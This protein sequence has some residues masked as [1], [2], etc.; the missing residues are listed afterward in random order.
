MATHFISD[1]HL[2]EAV[3][4]LNRL[5]VD[6]L[7]AWRGKIDALYILGDLFEYWVGDDD[8]SPFKREMLAAMAAFSSETPL[9]VMHGNRDFLLGPV[10]EADSGAKLL[11][12]P[13]EV[14][15][16]G[17]RFLLCHGDA[18]C[19]DDVAYQQFRA[20]VRNPAWQ[21][22]L[23]AKSLA[24]RHAIAAQIRAASDLKKQQ[25]GL[26][27]IGDVT[28]D[29][30]AE[31]LAEHDAP[32]LIHGHTHRPAHHQ[33][34]LPDGR[35]AERWVIA[36]WHDNAGGYLRVDEAGVAAHPLR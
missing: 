2:C 8:D 12:E 26:D 30:V 21:Q 22:A 4:G 6:T 3:P 9:F 7:A 34:T 31:L 24:E 27:E 36:D 32:T 1:L 35:T 17:R 29:A 13:T 25:T 10:F 28:E 15:L 33:H 18:L 19:R 23:L 20:M 14:T 11:G 16:Y 5:F